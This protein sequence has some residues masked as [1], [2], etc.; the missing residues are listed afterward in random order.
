MTLLEVMVSTGVLVTGMMATMQVVSTQVRF[1]RRAY[2]QTQAQTIAEKVLEDIS[3][4]GCIRDS[5]YMTN[6]NDLCGNLKRL[7]N[8]QR[9]FF[10]GPDKR[11]GE[12]VGGVY[13]GMQ[14]DGAGNPPPD[15]RQY[16]AT[17]DVDPPFEGGE[18][19]ATQLPPNMVNV[20]VTVSWRE[21][22]NAAPEAVALNTR[23]LP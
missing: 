3:S 6:P 8:T 7:D 16:L 2:A 12:R 1:N 22:P 17:I 14:L 18:S 20:R 15:A 9:Q 21:N 23:V 5:Q 4:R 13:V 10:W 11:L 19:Y